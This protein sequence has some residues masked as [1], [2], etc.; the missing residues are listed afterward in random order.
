MR[1]CVGAAAAAAAF[2]VVLLKAL[3]LKPLQGNELPIPNEFSQNLILE[4]DWV[5]SPGLQQNS[6]L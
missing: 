3:A 4:I 5:D 2:D 6:S 1:H